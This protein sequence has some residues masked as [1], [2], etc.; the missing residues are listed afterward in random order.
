MAVGAQENTIVGVFDDYRTAEQVREDLVKAGIPRDAIDV[1]S[2][3][4]AGT[5]GG[6]SFDSGGYHGGI[7]R[8]FHRLFGGEESESGHYAEAVRRG[9]S[10]VSVTVPADRIEQATRIMNAAG[11]VDIDRRVEQYRETG[12]K[13]YD[14]NAPAYSYEDAEAER[15][16]LRRSE[17]GGSIPVVEEELEIGKRVIRRGGV[18]V[19]SRVIDKPVEEQIELREEHARVER[20]RVDRPIGSGELGKL[21][22]QSIEVTETAEEPVV[23]KRARVKEEVVVGKETKTRTEKVRDTVRRTEVEVE[24]LGERDDYR[25]DFRR[26]WQE[27]YGKSGETYEAYEPAY[28]YGY[29]SA[30]DPRWR[31]RHWSDVEDDLRTDYERSHPGSA[32]ERTKAAVRHGWKKAEGRR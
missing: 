22:D 11:A 20:R 14:E 21:R 4:G 25:A 10:V 12:Y 24:R 16:R 19:Y 5:G 6:R 13:Q 18:R 32:W 23:Q 17:Q 1:R 8:F 29:R 9:N 7:S 15:D 27:E 2:N 28:E 3:F 31:G 26:H 30:S